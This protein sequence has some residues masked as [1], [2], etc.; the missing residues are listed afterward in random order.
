MIKVDPPIIQIE[1]PAF[2]G[3]WILGMVLD[4]TDDDGRALFV[5]DS[6]KVDGDWWSAVDL[7]SDVAHAALQQAAERRL[8]R[9]HQQQAE[10][11]QVDRYLASDRARLDAVVSEWEAA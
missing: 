10:D 8:A 4:G 3:N 2:G 5:V 7:L 9:L 11:Y 1:V 6:V